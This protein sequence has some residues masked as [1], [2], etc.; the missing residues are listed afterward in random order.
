MP[1]LRKSPSFPPY[2]LLDHDYVSKAQHKYARLEQLYHKSHVLSWDGKKV[3]AE[4]SAKHG[5]IHVSAET[6][7]RL[8]PVLSTLL[9]G[10][11]AAWNISA[12]LA[13]GIDDAEAKM[14][15]TAQVFD[16]ARHFYTLRDY[17]M[18]AG[19]ELPPLDGFALRLMR[20]LLDTPDLVHKL[21]GMQ[22]L[23][24]G[25]AISLF[26]SI[27]EAQIEPVLADLF[28][29]YE[30]DEAR[31][32]GLGLL[33]LPSLLEQLGPAGAL[34]MRLFQQRAQTLMTW[35]TRLLQ[36]HLRA[37]KIDLNAVVRRGLKLQE[38]VFKRVGDG[39]GRRSPPSARWKQLQSDWLDLSFP[40]LDK[41]LPPWHRAL[42]EGLDF[43]ARSGERAL[44]RLS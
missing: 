5:G 25:V 4:L 37:L 31:H 7:T 26:K 9:W 29:L 38:E 24:E 42:L 16:E 41:A 2:K 36:P 22:L 33:Y 12:D 6:R 20:E 3:L 10:E 1:F 40:P 8:A 17:V 27:S 35:E 14:A 28:R 30:R 39:P 23:V 32:I 44:R 15:A 34:R 19:I 11:L 21:L 13:L 43:A 18:Q